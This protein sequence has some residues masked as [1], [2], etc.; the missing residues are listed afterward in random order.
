MHSSRMRTTRISGH[1]SST[2]APAMHVMHAPLNYTC[3]LCLT[4]PHFATQ[5]RL[6]YR[7]L[8]LWTERMTDACENITFPQLLLRTLKIQHDFKTGKLD[9]SLTRFISIVI[10]YPPDIALSIGESIPERSHISY[11]LIYLNIKSQDTSS[12]PIQSQPGFKAHLHQASM[13]ELECVHHHLY[14]I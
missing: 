2:H 1:L 8:P 3:P 14:D 10:Y 7:S 13:I 12:V 4:C 6:L 5:P 9:S 11:L